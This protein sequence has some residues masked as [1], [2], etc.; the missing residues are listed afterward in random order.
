MHYVTDRRFDELI[1]EG[2]LEKLAQFFPS[3]LL[4]SYCTSAIS[5][6]YF[7]NFLLSLYATKIIKAILV[8]VWSICTSLLFPYLT[9]RLF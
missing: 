3:R 6:E 2:E 7:F 8:I 4:G 5:T 9:L 1:R